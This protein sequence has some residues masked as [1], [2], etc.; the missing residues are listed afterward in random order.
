MIIN[1]PY[2]G[3]NRKFDSKSFAFACAWENEI[4]ITKANVEYSQ[5][6]I[7]EFVNGIKIKFNM[8][9]YIYKEYLLLLYCEID[10]NENTGNSF[11]S[12]MIKI[13]G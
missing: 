1:S 3:N 13:K 5:T 6:K 11:P 9:I 7:E 10:I 4:F 8:E 2:S 12:L